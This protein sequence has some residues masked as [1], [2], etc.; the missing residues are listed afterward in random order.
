M[1]DSICQDSSPP[2]KDGGEGGSSRSVH[3]NSGIKE[4]ANMLMA[5]HNINIFFMCFC[6]S[7]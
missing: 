7:F 3:A 5:S 6:F 4:Q 2:V 1:S